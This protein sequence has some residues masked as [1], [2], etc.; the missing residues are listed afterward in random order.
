MHL[1]WTQTEQDGPDHS[2]ADHGPSTIK[3][4]VVDD[5]DFPA[6]IILAVLG[7]VSVF[8]FPAAGPRGDS[9][10]DHFVT[11]DNLQVHYV[12]SG[13][14]PTVVLIH[15]NAGGVEDFEFGAIDSLARKYR[16]VAIDRPGHGASDRAAAS[17]PPVEYQ[18]QLLHQTLS[19]LG[20][21]KPILVGHSWGGSL[22]LNYAMKYP[23]EVAAMVLLAPAA[24][25]EKSGSFLLSAAAK[26]PGLAELGGLLEKSIISPGLLKRD[27]DR[28]FYPQSVP[29]RYFKLVT[30]SW[31][32][33]KQ[34]KA[35]FEDESGLNDGL[36]K[37]C[38]QYSTIK[39]PTVIVTGDKDMI[40][41]PKDNAYRLQKV[42]ARSRLITLKNSGHEIP[43][44]RPKIIYAAL[45]LIFGKS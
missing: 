3:I 22:V 1:R 9:L 30:A 7:G 33:R 36:K 5:I 23:D 6:A 25:P 41:S 39:I 17:S 40:V 18:A 24:Y 8:A 10:S 28:A 12:E 11:V 44:T 27:L 43:Q 14:G 20:I 26:I 34:L 19:A 4:T 35:F 45:R 37:M 13:A 32:G 42:I 16:V 2:N 29:D 38:D 15:G 31:L 21:K